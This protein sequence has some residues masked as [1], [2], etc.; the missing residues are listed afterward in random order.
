MK[1]EGKQFRWHAG[2]PARPE[3]CNVTTPAET[4]MNSAEPDASTARQ[5]RGAT[6]VVAQ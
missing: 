6:M 5:L 2:T 4:P 1:K 3:H